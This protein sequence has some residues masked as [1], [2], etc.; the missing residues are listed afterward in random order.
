MKLLQ[1]R[2]EAERL[3]AE[4]QRQL[5]RLISEATLSS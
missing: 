3:E 5:D 1:L 2:Q 4:Y